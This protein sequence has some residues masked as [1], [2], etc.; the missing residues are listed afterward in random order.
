M[1]NQA[2]SEQS[3][4]GIL[5]LKLDEASKGQLQEEYPPRYPNVFYDHV[6]LVFEAHQA[7][8]NYLIGKKAVAHVLAYARNDHV[9]AVR[10]DTHG[11]P[12]TYG[13]PHVTLSTEEGIEAFESVAMLQSEHHEESVDPPL[14]LDGTIEFIPFESA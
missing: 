1:K 14:E 2:E 10:V 8:V 6:T 13:V 7:A 9:E 4:Q 12:D 3:P 5:W 11:L